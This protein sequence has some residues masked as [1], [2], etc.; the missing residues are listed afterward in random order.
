MNL[1]LKGGRVIDPSTGVDQVQNLLIK[2]GKIAGRVEEGQA[3]S[4][5]ELDVID[6][7]GKIL[8]PGLIDM[9]T[10]LREPGDEYK[11]TIASGSEAAAAGGFTSIACMP[12]TH[13]VN[14]NRSTTEFILKRAAECGLVNVYPIAA[15]SLK[16]EGAILSEFWDLK[17]AGAVGF[18][19]D[20]KPVMNSALMR[21]A[22]EYASSLDMPIIS[23]CEDVNLSAGGVMHE[24]AVSAE[25]G[26]VG[27]PAA[28]EEIMVAR[29]ILLAEYTGAHVHIAHVST[30]GSVRLIHEAKARGI[31]VTAETAPHYFMLT[32]E[33]LRNFDTFAKVYPPLRG[34]KDRE[35]IREGMND[36]AI[37][38]I[39]SDHA[40]HART[41]KELEFDYAANGITGLETSLSLSLSLVQEGIL[42]LPELIKK[43][44]INPAR[45]LHIPKGTLAAGADADITVIDT[46]KEWL[47]D[48]RMFRSRGKNTPFQ[49]QQL[50]GKA[51][52][53]I[54][55]GEIRFRD[56]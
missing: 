2:N 49:G 55:G 30:K 11:E 4:D 10:H 29:D 16:S 44:T 31:R 21:R 5:P 22:L 9:H 41:D 39:A 52:L 7:S 3:L 37:D 35:A 28:A 18:S 19:D 14:D 25:I 23:H 15:I 38:T 12:N 45:I 56:L 43:M 47:V 34:A 32:D 51:V 27:I 46:E 1:L 8:V 53:T 48:P 36:G 24:G 26:L 40:P 6:I 50:R 13:P 33:A 42:T 54:V 17:E 20:G